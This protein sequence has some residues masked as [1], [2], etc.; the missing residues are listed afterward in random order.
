MGID[1]K[2]E[3]LPLRPEP[4]AKAAEPAAQS[5]QAVTPT[6]YVECIASAGLFSDER[7]VELPYAQT[8]AWVPADHVIPRGPPVN[9]AAPAYLKVEVLNLFDADD[10]P[11]PGG[12]MLHRANSAIIRYMDTGDHGPRQLAVPIEK[13]VLEVTQKTYTK[14]ADLGGQVTWG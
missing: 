7:V 10:N 4:P 2:L 6:A 12:S 9:G 13:L 14:L 11:L 5:P 1:D 8:S 3:G